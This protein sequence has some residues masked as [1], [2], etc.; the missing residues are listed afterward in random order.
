VTVTYSWQ[1]QH[2]ILSPGL[3]NSTGRPLF[4]HRRFTFSDY[5]LEWALVRIEL[6]QRQVQ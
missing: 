4:Q 5:E 6:E 1:T 2:R 3:L